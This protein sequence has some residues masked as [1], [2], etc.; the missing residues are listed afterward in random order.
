MLCR[1]VRFSLVEAAVDCAGSL[2][3]ALIRFGCR[4]KDIVAHLLTKHPSLP[5][6]RVAVELRHALAVTWATDAAQGVATEIDK[7]GAQS[8]AGFGECLGDDQCLFERT[9]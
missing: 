3:T 7:A 4:G 8:T 5:S 9:A 2:G 6:K 1:P